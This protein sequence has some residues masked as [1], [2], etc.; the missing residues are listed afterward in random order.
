MSA[1][2]KKT[3]LIS[4]SG[5]LFL[6]IFITLVI[7]LIIALFLHPKSYREILIAIVITFILS[8]ICVNYISSKG[9]VI[10]T[11]ATIGC[12]SSVILIIFAIIY[13]FLYPEIYRELIITAIC[14]FILGVSCT[15]Y[16][17]YTEKYKN[18]IIQKQRDAFSR[19]SIGEKKK[20]LDD[21]FDNFFQWKISSGGDL[22]EF[23]CISDSYNGYYVEFYYD[24][25]YKRDKEYIHMGSRSEYSLHYIKV[26][27]NEI[28]YIKEITLKTERGSL[29]LPVKKQTKIHVGDVILS[30][31]YNKKLVD[32]KISQ[33][34]Q[35]N[36]EHEELLKR[37]EI[38]KEKRKLLKKERKE[39]IKKQA[40]RELLE[41]GFVDETK[42]TE[43][44]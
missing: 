40:L 13:C 10:E 24:S 38:N 34:K 20:F 31:N 26:L 18:K 25:S 23:V 3:E 11:L 15:Y 33:E 35:F 41:D 30:I 36:E 42:D 17:S 44:K 27:L 7:G 8:R 16:M 29:S 2:E 19:L 43:T 37:I 21:N 22:E 14:T 4:R 39:E 5:C 32:K 6:L 12:F 28:W 9:E 1:N